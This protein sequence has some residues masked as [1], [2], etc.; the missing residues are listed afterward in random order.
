[1]FGCIGVILYFQNS[2]NME[3][4][5]GLTIIIGMMMSSTLLVFYMWL[6]RFPKWVIGG[7]IL[8]YAV[9]ESSFLI[10]NLDK[11]PHGG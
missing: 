8:V 11:L 7:F 9:V 10:A 6:K 3:A 5:Y 1:M 4:A 2:A